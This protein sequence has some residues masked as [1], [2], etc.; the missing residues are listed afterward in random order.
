MFKLIKKIPLNYDGIC[1]FNNE[2]L[3][4]K[5]NTIAFYDMDFNKVKE[6]TLSKD[7]KFITAI[8]DTIF[9]AD[10]KEI[11]KFDFNNLIKLDIDIDLNIV[12][13]NNI[14]DI[15][16]IITE[17]KIYSY[18]K[19]L[20]K[21]LNIKCSNIFNIDNKNYFIKKTDLYD[22]KK[23]QSFDFD[24][25]DCCYNKCLILLSDSIYIYNIDCYAK[26]T[27]LLKCLCKEDNIPS[28]IACIEKA[29]A[30]ILNEEA[31][32]IKKAICL[33]NN[34]C[35]LIKIND[36]VNQTIKNVILLEQ[37]LCTK[38]DIYNNYNNKK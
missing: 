26:I 20:K 12:N 9:L 30:N 14:N 21:Y 19:E 1:L 34:I 5:D 13:I 3:L 17:D 10:D 27:K 25:K 15:L 28:S 38:L 6:I 32:K 31:N 24:I 11:Y 36:S 23:I 33:S 2:Y 35:D 7:F 18:D 29:L 16:I 8:K 4:L 37:V 22:N